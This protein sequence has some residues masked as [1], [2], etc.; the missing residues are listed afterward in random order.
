MGFPCSYGSPAH[1]YRHHYPVPK[2]FGARARV[3]RLPKRSQPSLYLNQI[4]ECIALFEAFPV[5]THVT[6]YMF[7]DSLKEPFSK[8]LERGCYLHRPFG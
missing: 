2:A 7:S 1:T 3:V 8:V 4:G 6:V 5:F